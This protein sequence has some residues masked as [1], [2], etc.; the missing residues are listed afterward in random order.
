M[1]VM[2]GRFIAFLKIKTL[3]EC[4]RKMV[5]AIGPPFYD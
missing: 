1:D 2:Q 5:S 4:I 3:G